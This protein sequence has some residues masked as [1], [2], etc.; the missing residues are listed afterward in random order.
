LVTAAWAATRQKDSYLRSQFLRIK[1]RRG[2]KKGDPWVATLML[3][4]TYVMLLDGVEYHD[5]GPHHFAQHDKE[6]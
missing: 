3:C 5:L 6:P 2:A 4:A 1:S